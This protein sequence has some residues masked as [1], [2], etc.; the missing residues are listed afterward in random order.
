MIEPVNKTTNPLIYLWLSEVVVDFLTEY[1]IPPNY[2]HY[3]AV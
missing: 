2:A 3:E 1:I